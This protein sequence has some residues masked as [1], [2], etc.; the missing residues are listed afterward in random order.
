MVRT[1]REMLQYRDFEERF[2][3]LKLGGRVGRE[4]FGFDRYLNQGF[5]KSREWRDLRHEVIARDEAC[6]MALEGEPIRGR[7]LVHHINPLVPSDIVHGGE[8]LFDMDNLVT[9]CH[10]THNAIH[11]GDASLLPKPFVERQ[12]G[13]TRLW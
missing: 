8:S 3:Y 11:Y 13:D 1:Y 6:D 12:P 5:Y 9:V 10:N 4:T 2:E 7:I